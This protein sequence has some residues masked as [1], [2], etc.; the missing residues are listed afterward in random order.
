MPCM[1]V[2]MF[3]GFPGHGHIVNEYCCLFAGAY[4]SL[5]EQYLLLSQPMSEAY[6]SIPRCLLF[7]NTRCNSNRK[8]VTKKHGT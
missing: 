4:S 1:I 3:C 6:S 8:F 2:S 7:E 5:H